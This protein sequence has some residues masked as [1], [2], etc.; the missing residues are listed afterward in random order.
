[1]QVKKN[2]VAAAEQALDSEKHEYAQSLSQYKASHMSIN[3]AYNF[4]TKYS[5][6]YKLLHVHACICVWIH[7]AWVDCSDIHI[8]CTM[9]GTCTNTCAHAYILD[10]H[11]HKQQR[12]CDPVPEILI[13]LT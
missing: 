8:A 4:Q 5:K 11:I 12:Y 1:M 10:T 13:F 6:T 3:S 7:T 2:D 9:N